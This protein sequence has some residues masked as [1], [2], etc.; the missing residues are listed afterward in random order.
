VTTSLEG[1]AKAPIEGVLDELEG[2]IARLRPEAL[3]RAAALRPLP[4]RESLARARAIYRARRHRAVIFEEW[5]D[6]F[7]DPAWDML[8]DLFVADGTGKPVSI[9]SACIGSCVPT[10]TGLRWVSL[11]ERR[12]LLVRKPDPDDRRRSL[13]SLSEE[14]RKKMQR[15][16]QTTDWPL[17]PS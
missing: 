12:G 7:A 13:V 15:W 11:L 5:G 8:L 2:V 3:E 17:P 9:S 16:L 14:A 4:N 1:D 6:L 10:T